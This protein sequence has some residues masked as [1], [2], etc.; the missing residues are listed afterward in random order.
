MRPN[1]KIK[2]VIPNIKIEKKLS[3]TL[4][5]TITKG[6]PIGLLLTLTY[7]EEKTEETS[8]VVSPKISVRFGGNKPSTKIL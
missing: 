7:A 3:T 4:T 1:V 6:T 8:L 2:E 5:T